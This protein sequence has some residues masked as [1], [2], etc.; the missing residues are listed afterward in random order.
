MAPGTRDPAPGT[1]SVGMVPGAP[2]VCVYELAGAIK[3]GHTRSKC[4]VNGTARSSLWLTDLLGMIGM[5]CRPLYAQKTDRFVGAS[6]QNQINQCRTEY[7][8]EFK[9]VPRQP[10]GEGHMGVIGVSINDE[11]L[12]AGHG[13]ETYRVPNHTRLHAGQAR[14]DERC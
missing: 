13:V 4:A 10:R 1:Q 5:K 11:V 2:N 6:R 12:V 14:G 7:R 8:G 9:P 3:N